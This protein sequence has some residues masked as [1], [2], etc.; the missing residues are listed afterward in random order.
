MPGALAYN[1]G[2]KDTMKQI[3]YNFKC[4]TYGKKRKT[5]CTSY[6]ICAF[7]RETVVPEKLRAAASDVNALSCLLAAI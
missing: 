6:H 2:F 5:V 3:E 7:K 4:C 1:A